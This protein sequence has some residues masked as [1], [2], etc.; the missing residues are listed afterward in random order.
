[1]TG[2]SFHY[3]TGA[4]T[5]IERPHST[6]WRVL[7]QAVTAQVLR[8]TARLEIE[9]RKP[10]LVRAGEAFF[11][12]PN[13]R[14]CSTLITPGVAVSR[15]STFDYQVTGS[16]SVFSLLDI[17][18]LFRKQ[19]ATRIGEINA[20][21]AEVSHASD[22]RAL[23]QREALSAK[24]LATLA[25]QGRQKPAAAALLNPDSRVTGVLQLIEKELGGDLSRGRLARAAHLSPSRFHSV[26]TRVMGESPG[27]Y[28]L[29]LR[30]Q[31]AQQW[32]I[33]TDLA[34][35]EIARRCGY[36]DPF[37][38]SRLFKQRFGASPRE[39]RKSGRESLFRGS[40]R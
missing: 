38:F 18:P 6:G 23:I 15:W 30:L 39:Y 33:G 34:V 13:V 29:R 11:V 9:G 1:M 12:A 14:H 5:E 19:A 21:L 8:G 2:L 26:F 28:V 17:A 32:L 16:I 4:V 40:N 3:G 27:E 36:P 7:P 10:I 25:A 24:L 20:R 35:N 31:R 37:H 22:L